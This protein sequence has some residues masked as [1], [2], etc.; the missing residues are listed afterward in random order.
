MPKKSTKKDYLITDIAIGSIIKKKM[1]TRDWD[2]D[3]LARNLTIQI[4]RLLPS[5]EL[6]NFF[7]PQKEATNDSFRKTTEITSDFFDRD[8]PIIKDY[9]EY[10]RCN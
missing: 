3:K 8:N 1:K 9:L 7:M 5:N 4:Y 2:A 10:T 6:P